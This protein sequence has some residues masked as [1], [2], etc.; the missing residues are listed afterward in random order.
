[1]ISERGESLFQIIEICERKEVIDNN[2]HHNTFDV[3][4][5]LSDTLNTLRYLKALKAFN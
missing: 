2:L 1:M 5:H 4:H 3:K